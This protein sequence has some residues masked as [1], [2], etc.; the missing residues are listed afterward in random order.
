MNY[1]YRHGSTA[2][3]AVLKLYEDGGVMRFYSGFI[4][5]LIHG[6]MSRF[7]DTASSAGTL[8]LLESNSFMKS[9]VPTPVKMMVGSVGAA[10]YRMILTPIDT[11]KTT[12]QT[13]G[14]GGIL[15]LTTRVSLGCMTLVQVIDPGPLA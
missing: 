9:R 3:E 8:Y 15:T 4:A 13:L 5:A 2:V 1:Q 7:G 10:G 11:V 14:K 12:L 6:P